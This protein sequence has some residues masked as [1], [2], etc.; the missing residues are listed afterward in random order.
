MAAQCNGT[1]ALDHEGVGFVWVCVGWGDLG[2]RVRRYL[3]TS[4]SGVSGWTDVER[5]D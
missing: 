5:H 2:R 4:T 1:V 3:A